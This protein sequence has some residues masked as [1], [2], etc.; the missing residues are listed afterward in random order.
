M[1]IINYELTA[2]SP[3]VF[4]RGE[5]I[6]P[7]A[8]DEEEAMT[9]EGTITQKICPISDSNLGFFFFTVDVMPFV[10]QPVLVF[11]LPE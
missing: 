1:C 10:N 4:S 8:V 7:S 3:A 5:C 9:Q 11:S 2:V 6:H